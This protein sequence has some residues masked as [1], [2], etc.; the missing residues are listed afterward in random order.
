MY[1]LIYQ[2]NDSKYRMFTTADYNTYIIVNNF[3]ELK[4]GCYSECI[5]YIHKLKKNKKCLNL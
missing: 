4:R 2:S 5:D 3:G 1:K